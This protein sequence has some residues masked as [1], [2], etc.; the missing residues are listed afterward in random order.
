MGKSLARVSRVVVVVTAAAS[1][2]SK[3]ICVHQLQLLLFLLHSTCNRIS[4]LSHTGYC[5]L[6]V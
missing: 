6:D 5:T 2:A 3:W 1:A 4:L